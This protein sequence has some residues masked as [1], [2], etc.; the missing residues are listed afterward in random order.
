MKFKVAKLYKIKFWDHTI[1]SKATTKC[2]VVGW[3]ID[4]N[5]NRVLLSHWIVVEFG[6]EEDLVENNYEYTSII[7]STIIWKKLIH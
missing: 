3:C 1:G 2:E 6:E 5:R 7:K 4:D